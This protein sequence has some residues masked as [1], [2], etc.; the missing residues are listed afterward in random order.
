VVGADEPAFEEEATQAAEE[1]AAAEGEY[2]DVEDALEETE[3][4]AAEETQAEPTQ[5]AQPESTSSSDEEPEE[6]K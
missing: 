1:L 4:E 5:E 2:V 6:G 3:A